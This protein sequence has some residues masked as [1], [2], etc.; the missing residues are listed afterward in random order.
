[1]NYVAFRVHEDTMTYFGSTIWSC[2]G[3]GGWS[4]DTRIGLEES[5]MAKESAEDVEGC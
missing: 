4:F 3:A 2:S 5:A 1:M